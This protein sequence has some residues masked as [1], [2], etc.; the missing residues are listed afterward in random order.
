MDVPI[1][2]GTK[3]EPTPE[4]LHLQNQSFKVHRQG[5]EPWTP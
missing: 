5:L 4:H 1:V 3:K 2:M